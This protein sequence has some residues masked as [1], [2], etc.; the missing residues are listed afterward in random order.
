MAL[1]ILTCIAHHTN[2]GN[3]TTSVRL[4]NNR[5]ELSFDLQDAGV[6]TTVQKIEDGD[7]PHEHGWLTEETIEINVSELTGEVNLVRMHEVRNFEPVE[8]EEEKR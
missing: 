4:Y 2:N 3:G 6:A 8:E 7:A 1:K 5:D